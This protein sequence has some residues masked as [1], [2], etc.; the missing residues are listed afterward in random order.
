MQGTVEATA[1]QALATGRPPCR[2]HGLTVQGVG[3]QA[4]ARVH[5]VPH[6]QGKHSATRQTRG[7]DS[8][9]QLSPLHRGTGLAVELDFLYFTIKTRSR[10]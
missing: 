1:E 7:P 4:A 5:G 8:G 6:L 9:A 3:L 10:C 2:P